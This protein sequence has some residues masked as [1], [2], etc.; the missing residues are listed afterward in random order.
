[1]GLQDA[2]RALAKAAGDDDLA[3]FGHRLAD[4]IER[5]LHRRINEAT[6]VDH[7]HVGRVVAVHH[8]VA[9]DTKLGEDAFGIDEGLGATKG[10]E[11]DFG[12]A[13]G[14]GRAG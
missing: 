7:H 11:A 8:V 3:V 5:L 4:G 1:M 14:H 9:F 13:G 2:F 6:G 10:D 12:L